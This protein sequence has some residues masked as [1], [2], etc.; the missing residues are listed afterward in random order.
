M[1]ELHVMKTI[2]KYERELMR[3]RER[4][5]ERRIR[6]WGSE[7]KKRYA[8]DMHKL[9][10]I[11]T[12]ERIWKR[13]WNKEREIYVP[14]YMQWKRS[15]TYER[16]NDRKRVK[17]RDMYVYYLC[18]YYYYLKNWIIGRIIEILFF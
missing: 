10:V 15:K 18:M 16:E 1:N 4:E 9:Y 12:I 2:E 3:E 8:R 11:K 14:S 17:K 13:E 6:E 7:N 5:R